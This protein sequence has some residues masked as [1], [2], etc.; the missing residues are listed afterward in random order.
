MNQSI[1]LD[2]LRIVGQIFLLATLYYW[3]M[4]LLKGT[5]GLAQITCGVLLLVFIYSVSSFLQLSVLRWIVEK[6][7]AA[8]PIILVVL[9]QSEIR[10]LLGIFARKLLPVVPSH[11]YLEYQGQ[12]EQMTDTL[13]GAA[14]QMSNTKTGAL[15]AI[16]QTMDLSTYA[17]TGKRVDALLFPGNGLVETIFYKGSP[18]HDGGMVVHGNRVEA[19][20]CV[21]PLCENENVR[22]DYGMRHQAATGLSEETDALVLVVSEENGVIHLVSNGMMTAIL[23]HSLLK[24]TM[25][26]SLHLPTPESSPHYQFFRRAL[27]RLRA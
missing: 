13:C 15:I 26:R 1:F 19:A 16:Q 3:I 7:F 5:P 6:V 12:L 21:F 4:R 23:D 2:I 22:N 17:K 18:L 8:L 25:Q 10:R 14:I 9:F 24:I 20:G 27:M 11:R